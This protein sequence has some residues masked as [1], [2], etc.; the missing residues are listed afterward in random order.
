MARLKAVIAGYAF[1][2]LFARPAVIVFG[3][4]CLLAMSLAVSVATRVPSAL[5]LAFALPLPAGVIASQV[6]QELEHTSFA[7]TIP[8]LRLSV[9]A[10]VV[11][12]GCVACALSVFLSTHLPGLT[13][14]ALDVAAA[15]ATLAAAAGAG[16]GFGVVIFDRDAAPRGLVLALAIVVLVAA[17]TRLAP[18]AVPA[19]ATMTLAIFLC[20]VLCL[21]ESLSL[22]RFR[23][24]PFRPTLTWASSHLPSAVA[25][26]QVERMTQRRPRA[27]VWDRPLANAGIAAWVHASG[28]A[29]HGFRRLG[30]L[31]PIVRIGL[32][33]WCLLLPLLQPTFSRGVVATEIQH[34]LLAPTGA[35]HLFLAFLLSFT[36]FPALGPVPGAPLGLLPGLHYPLSRRDR[37]RVMFRG[38]VLASFACGL[39][40]AIACVVPLGLALTAAGVQVAMPGV[41]GFI[42]PLIFYVSV[43]PFL[44]WRAT[45]YER[46]G[47]QAGSPAQ[48]GVENV[49]LWAGL[50][51]VAL[52]VSD[53]SAVFH[54]MSPLPTVLVL[55]AVPAVCF[56][57]Y[58]R[59]VRTIHRRGDL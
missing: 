8:R 49:L 14:A 46:L 48:W 36:I 37:A 18:L 43:L 47:A 32:F 29:R 44:F 58:H 19:A 41:P 45:H 3:A 4:V 56:A 23:R 51:A 35:Y 16:Y 15:R 33:S 59:V 30:W 38:H 54:S 57:A 50:V 55:V 34:L 28:F 21:R 10:G 7:W 53:V 20:A 26:Y 40:G 13:P 2:G 52:L 42:P 39:A 6:V 25:R 27:A 24:R 9:L 12:A 31:N 1:G 11:A 17:A 22:E 5:L